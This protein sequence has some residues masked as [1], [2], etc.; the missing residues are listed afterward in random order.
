MTHLK[1]CVIVI[2]A[3]DSYSTV[4]SRWLGLKNSLNEHSSC[5]MSPYKFRLS[6]P[7]RFNLSHG[8][9]Y[10]L[11][12]ENN[13]HWAT[14][15]FYPLYTESPL[16]VLLVESFGCGGGTAPCPG[17]STSGLWSVHL[18]RQW[19]LLKQRRTGLC[20]QWA[21]QGSDLSESVTH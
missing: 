3:S 12:D 7:G 5:S 14:C 15:T 4:T 2:A 13:L 18:E 21:R 19:K 1:Q 9:I 16:Y 8:L 11:L 6:W 20:Q 10:I 17:S